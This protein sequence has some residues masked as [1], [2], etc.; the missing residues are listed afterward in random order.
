MANLNDN[1]LKY[2]IA[3]DLIPG[4]GGVLAKKIIRSAGSTE[5]V[6]KCSMDFLQKIPGIGKTLAGNIKNP[7]ILAE[8]EREIEFISRYRIKALYYLDDDY[9][10]RLKEC[11]DS[12]VVLFIKGRSELDNQKVISI[13]GTRSASSYGLGFCRQLVSDLASRGHDPLIVSGLAYGIDICAHKAALDNGLHTAAVLAHG[14]ATIYP[15]AHRR[16]AGKI[17]KEGTLVTDFVSRTMPERGNFLK[18][19]RIIAG[20]ADATIVVESS[21]KGGALITAE[22]AN[23]YNRDVFALPGRVCDVRSQGCNNL[24]KINKAA[25]IEKVEDLEYILGWD[26]PVSTPGNKRVESFN[27]VNDEE[28][29]IL[30]LLSGT[31]GMTAD[32]ISDDTKLEAGKISFHLLN[33]EFLG[34]VRSLPGKMY[35]LSGDF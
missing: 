32:Q 13:V 21:M 4:I 14:M 7:G 24:I 23:S 11:A 31:S 19:N 27:G 5:E 8:A 6:F 10:E 16:V 26:P 9:P 1:S 18:R 17:G 15:P 20:L 28:R 3:M 33:L 25:L 35:R 2:K 12:P 22:L 34:Y 30:R 29:A